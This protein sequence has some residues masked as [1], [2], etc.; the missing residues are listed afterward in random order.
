M[1]GTTVSGQKRSLEELLAGRAKR[2]DRKDSSTR[3]QEA[4]VYLLSCHQDLSQ[5]LSEVEAPP[6]KKICNGDRSDCTESKNSA[7]FTESFVGSTVRGQALSLGLPAGILTAKAAA[8]NIQRICQVPVAATRGAVLSQEQRDSLCCL[9][10]SL[11]GLLAENC[12]CRSLFSKEIWDRQLPPVLEVVWHLNNEGIVRLEE[13]LESCE[14]SGFAV[15]W[16]CSEIHSLCLHMESS[17]VDPQFAEQIISDFQ[18]VLVGSGFCYSSDP[19]KKP[20][21][22]RITEKNGGC[23]PILDLKC[24]IHYVDATSFRLEY[25]LSEI[26]AMVIRKIRM[27]KALVLMIAPFWPRWAWFVDPLNLSIQEPDVEDGVALETTILK[28]KVFSDDVIS[29][30]VQAVKPVYSKAYNRICLSSTRLLDAVT[31]GKSDY[32]NQPRVEQHWLSAFE[33]SRYRARVF[34]E[35]LEQFFIHTLTQTLTYKPKL[36][37]SY[38]IRSQGN[39]SFVKTC[40]LLTDLYRKLFVALS[41][42]KLTAQIRLV[43]ENQE[44]NWHHVLTCVSCLVIYQ[45]DAQ[46]LVKDLLTSILKQAFENYELECLITV[47][48]IARQA[49]LEGP[50]AFVSYT[51]WFKCTFGAAS[52]YHNSSKKSLVFLLKFLS[53]LVPFEAPQYLKVHILHPPYVTTKYRPLL[54]EYIALAKTRLADMKVSIEDMGLYEDLSAGPDKVEPQS[55]AR[56][57]VETAVRIF[58]NTGKVPASVMEASIFRRPYFTSRFL[59]ALL[60]PRVLPAPPDALMLLINSLKRADKIPSNMFIAYLEACEQEKHRKMEGKEKMDLSLHEEPLGRLQSALRDLCPLVADTNKFEEVSAQVAVISDRLRVV[61]GYGKAEDD[62][63]FAELIIPEVGT[64]LD[65][66]DQT[67]ADLLLTCFCQCVMAASSTNP[68]ERQGH[69]PS[70]YLK[71]LCGHHRAFSAVLSRKMQLL[72]HQASLLR[73]SHIIGLAAFSIH[74]HECQAE[75][76]SPSTGMPS[77]ERFW[78]DLLQ[79]LCLNSMLVC[80]RFCTAAVCYAFCRYSLHSSGASADCLPPLFLQKLQYLLPRLF[81]EARGEA[82][83]EWKSDAPFAWISLS[84]PSAGWKGAALILWNQSVLQE[85]LKLPSFQ[86]SFRNWLLWEM[87]LHPDKDILCDTERQDYQRWAV[88]NCYLPESS[89]A[90]SCKGDLEQACAIMIDAVLEF[91]SRSEGRSAREERLSVQSHSCTGLTDIMCRLQELICDLV[92]LNHQYSRSYF[93]FHAFHLRLAAT[94]YSKEMSVRLKRQGELEM[95]CRILLGLPPLLL[96]STRS[97]NGV[98]TLCSEHF[99]R[100]VNVELKNLGPRGCALPYNITVHFFRGV[101]SLSAQ[102]DDP[103]E[104]V[105][106]IL[107]TCRSTCPIMITSAALWWPQLDSLLSCQWNRLYSTDLPKELALLMGLQASVDRCLSQGAALPLSD[108]A[109]LPAAFVYF[110]LQRKKLPY[111]QI[112]VFLSSWGTKAVELLTTILFFSIMDLIHVLLKGGAEVKDMLEYCVQVIH[113]LDERGGCWLSLFQLTEERKPVLCRLLHRTASEEFLQLLPLAFYSLV[114]S[115]QMEQ[116][117]LQSDFLVVAVH[118][119][120]RLTQLFIDGNPL[121]GSLMNTK[122]L[123][124]QD[125]FTH[126]RQFLLRCLPMCQKPSCALMLQLQESCTECD[127]ELAAV[128]KR[129]FQ[130]SDDLDELE[131]DPFF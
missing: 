18:K 75:L 67:V 130:T 24:L 78:E 6:F 66:Q 65:T 37:V 131:G 120:T 100:F 73:D 13:L 33:V 53:D 107:S 109:W 119:Y 23:C 125:V 64:V 124:S 113:W 88:I 14:D 43:L 47:F 80:L 32:S 102:C 117:V 39:W 51:E 123:D 82:F 127:P 35:S 83:S 57:D 40:P 121:D 116:L 16:F 111:R 50:A 97:D 93:L 90:G 11:K 79:L 29:T 25:L 62:T 46:Q 77:L 38:A 21:Q 19:G 91:C 89:V 20:E 128:L 41:A 4:A 22:P 12:F 101:L 98:T 76:R 7:S 92:T 129:C 84:L 112:L 104:G 3:L 54:M 115:L 122:T 96:I 68:P 48:L 87:S 2:L 114:T 58:E 26:S 30:M 106:S 8:T 74:L 42:E 126:G 105:N 69:W 81:W 9:L 86:L 36:K 95:C 34:P 72:G 108:P 1:S 59:P 31:E 45:C 71:M 94:A 60:A 61:M 56:Q 49:A 63:L 10:N 44:V 99:F 85:L 5:F 55:Q 70:L 52:A 118:M 27:E 103:T 17:P 15:N 28:W 110:T